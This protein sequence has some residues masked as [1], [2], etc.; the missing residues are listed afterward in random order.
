[1][2]D[3][4]RTWIHPPATDAVH[5]CGSATFDVHHCSS[6]RVAVVATGE[7]DAVNCRALGHFVERHTRKSNQLVLDLRPVEFFGSAGFTALHFVSA[8]CARRDVDWAIIGGDPVRR[9][10]A[11]CDP[12]GELPLAEDLP[13][14]LTRLDRLAQCR[15][16][17][18]WTGTSG[19]VAAGVGR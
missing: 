18:M 5:R 12:E 14:A 8:H 10:L 3:V 6:S 17:V 1:V 11:I 15:H 9:L 7:I 16:A 19:W 13:S 4:G 2:I